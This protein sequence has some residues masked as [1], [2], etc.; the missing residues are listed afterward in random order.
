MGTVT[1]D[2]LNTANFNVWAIKEIQVVIDHFDKYP[3]VT[4]KLSDYL[5]FKQCFDIVKKR[6]HL[7][8]E[9]LIKILELKSFLNLGLSEK[10]KEAFPNIIPVNRPE[11]I[12]KGIPDPYWVSGF[13]N[14]DGSFYLQFRDRFTKVSSLLPEV[15]SIAVDEPQKRV[16][17]DYKKVVL[18]FGV[19][20]HS[21]DEKLLIGLLDY[22][23][24]F[25]SKL[26]H[27]YPTLVGTN[28]NLK[29]SFMASHIYKPKLPKESVTLYFRKFSDIVNIIIPFFEEYPLI[30]YKKLDF[31]DFKKVSEIVKSKEHLTSALAPVP[32]AGQGEGFKKIEIINSTMNLRR[33]WS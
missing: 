10:L 6:E 13:I 11:Y 32:G 24:S 12:F 31:L 15:G 19:C 9:G 8:D 16:S 14:G 20:L 18:S 7:T 29:E 30:G 23:K 4:A 2:K 27:I 1:K 21:R 28:E 22:F 17:T 25:E 33:P 5:L 26:P 3:L